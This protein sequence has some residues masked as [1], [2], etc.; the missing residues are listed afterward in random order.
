LEIEEGECG[1][2]MQ[3]ERVAVLEQGKKV[4]RKCLAAYI[5]TLLYRC[6]IEDVA[7]IYR[8]LEK[9]ENRPG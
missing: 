8:I 5:T 6:P 3:K 9:G 7:L 1:V 4:C 2:C